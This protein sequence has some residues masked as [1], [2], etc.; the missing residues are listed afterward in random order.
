MKRIIHSVA[1]VSAAISML[2]A[3]PAMATKVYTAEENPFET[4]APTGAEVL[5]LASLKV[6]NLYAACAFAPEKHLEDKS[7]SEVEYVVRSSNRKAC[8]FYFGGIIHVLFLTPEARTA[9]N[10]CPPSDITFGEQLNGFMQWAKRNMSE[11]GEE[12]AISG[13]LESFSSLHP[14][15]KASPRKSPAKDAAE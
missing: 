15:E 11:K 6:N 14:C 7:M 2:C 10:Y 3:F 1:A 9:L 12:M 13:I 4:P 5:S 8:D